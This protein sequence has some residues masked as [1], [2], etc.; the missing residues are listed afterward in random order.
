MKLLIYSHFFAPSVG[1][2][3]TVVQ[4]L[5]KGLAK[6]LSDNG[7]PLYEVSLVTQTPPGVSTDSLLSYRVIR[8]PSGSKLWQ[9]IR[10]ADIVHV[11]G[12]AIP[13]IFYSLLARKPVVVEHHG[14][15]TICPT[16]QLLQEPQNVPCPGH[17]MNG[18][19]ASCL[20]CR[21]SGN[22]FSS[23]RLWLLTFFRRFLCQH[24]TVNIVPT[25]WL[26]RQLKL[27]QTQVVAHG[28]SPSPSFARKPKMGAPP[29][30]VFLGRLVSTKGVGVLLEAAKRLRD[31]E[32]RFELLVVGT[33]PERQSLETRAHELRLGMQVRFLGGLAKDQVDALLLKAAA[34]V[35]PSLGGE[36]FGMV[37]AESMLRGLPVI[38]S[39]LGAF[40]E[41]LGNT[42]QTFRTGD[43]ADLA[44]HIG[45]ILDDPA[46]AQRFG[47][48]AYQR[49]QEIFSEPRMVQEHSWIYRSLLRG[50]SHAGPRDV[51]SKPR[52][53]EI[54]TTK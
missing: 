38:A 52:N 29:T 39:D 21:L 46:L 44:L 17:F 30:V 5:A 40:V 8:Q 13:A 36:V 11:A 18:N 28:L 24:V 43:A 20:R 14:F 3:E 4:T 12:A 32:R 15:Q 51:A 22:L 31:K 48:A 25:L 34:V 27:P 47:E 26:R 6:E 37:V 42:G 35:V 49:A 9:L 7:S 19:H 45:R 16:G 50:G 10:E 41:L 33:G 23:L 1:G 54:T 2:V 53:R